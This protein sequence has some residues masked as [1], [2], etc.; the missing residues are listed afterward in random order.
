MF[1]GDGKSCRKVSHENALGN[2]AARRVKFLY[3]RIR[4]G[5]VRLF[6]A[7][8]RGNALTVAI[9]SAMHHSLFEIVDLMKRLAPLEWAE[10]WDNVGLLIEAQEAAVRRILLTI[11]LTEE[12]LFEA[13]SL[14]TNLIIAYHPPI[15]S[16]LKRLTQSTA[17]ER[18][19]SGAIRANIAVYSPHTAL[20]AAPNGM[21]DWLIRALGRGKTAA[22]V[23]IQ[24]A[25]EGVGMGRHIQLENATTL[26]ELTRRI[27]QYLGLAQLRVAAAAHHEAGKFVE[28]A[29]VCAGAGGSV[30]ERCPPVDLLLTGEMRHHD[31]L[32]RVAAGTSVVLTDHTNSERGY[33]PQLKAHLI[34]NLGVDVAISEKDADPLRIQ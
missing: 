29:A 28:R 20:D 10:P 19:V 14:N 33:L 27:K 26:S 3:A 18:V 8:R 32:A 7:L 12:V 25:P 11:D 4:G 5:C 6:V 34:D 13:K 21:N 22:I 24:N 31:V 2:A 1:L 9:W 16:G 23:P 17:L 30:F 15:F